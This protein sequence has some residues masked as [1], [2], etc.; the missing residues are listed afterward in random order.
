[1]SAL[2]LLPWAAALTS[3]MAAPAPRLEGQAL[4]QSFFRDG[5]YAGITETRLGL[6]CRVFHPGN[7]DDGRHPL[8]IWGNGTHASPASYRDLLEHWASH[9]LVVVA[10]MAPNAGRGIEM[11]DC[12]N[13]AIE[14]NHKDGSPF[15]NKLDTARIGVAGHSQGGGG[16]LMLGRDLRISTVIAIQPYVLG[17]SHNPGASASQHGPILLLSGADD[18][19]ASPSTNQQ[20]VFDSANVPVTWLTLR[21]AT[22]MA[23]MSTGGSYRGPM[24]AWLRWKLLDDSQAARLFEGNDCVLCADERWDVRRKPADS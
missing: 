10:A 16:A 2:R 9:G 17:L 5:I 4:L 12:L 22:H 24:T 11:R 1:M 13:L 23:P 6:H 8:V 20:P 18:M 7:M 3:C 19:T 15:Q 21:G 14:Q